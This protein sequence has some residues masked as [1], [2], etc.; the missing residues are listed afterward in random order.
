MPEADDRKILQVRVSSN[1]ADR[2]A[3]IA[4]AHNKSTSQ[5]LREAVE[6]YVA[7][8]DTDQL[9]EALRNRLEKNERRR[10]LG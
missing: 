9:Q 2:F 5:L 3:A 6:E 8:A 1:L 7:G 10:V 4:R